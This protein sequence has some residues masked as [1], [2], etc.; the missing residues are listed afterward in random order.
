TVPPSANEGRISMDP[1]LSPFR[2]TEILSPGRIG[3]SY[4]ARFPCRS[5]KPRETSGSCKN[6]A[7]WLPPCLSGSGSETAARA[8]F[9]DFL[10]FCLRQG[11]RRPVPGRCDAERR[12]PVSRKALRVFPIRAGGPNE[13]FRG[14][15]DIS[16]KN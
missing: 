7:P 5:A 6:T 2:M 15:E 14:K 4:F 11:G 10:S 16:F 9:P 3:R 13:T 1:I 8:F 12:G